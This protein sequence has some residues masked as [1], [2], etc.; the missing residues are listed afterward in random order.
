MTY[1]EARKMEAVFRRYRQLA[2]DYWAA[3]TPINYGSS[4]WMAGPGAPTH[5]D[6]E[7]SLELR[8]HLTTL[9]PEV[10]LYA[11]HLGVGVGGQSFPA[12]AVGGPVI[13][14]NL[15]S[16]VTDQWVGHKHVP[17]AT[18]LDAIDRCIGAAQF[19]KRTLGA[20]LVK[21][22]CWL[23]DVP[24]LIVG[25][26]FEVMRK[27]GVPDSIVESTGAQ[28]L[29]AIFTGLLWLAGIAYTAYKTGLAAAFESIIAQ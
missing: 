15:L 19:A 21:P 12:P 16:C 8:T 18:V 27:A 7:K 6:T 14:F 28:V 20:R 9:E 10:M 25:W 2:I 23:V 4:G 26:P 13:P 24:A 1:W 29:K 22:W 3:V 17:V 5:Q 11:Q